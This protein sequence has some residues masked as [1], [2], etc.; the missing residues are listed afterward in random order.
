MG[1]PSSPYFNEEVIRKNSSGAY[2]NYAVQEKMTSSG[3]MT[4]TAILSA[5][6]AVSV[7][8][9]QIFELGNM[10]HGL[11]AGCG[12]LGFIMVLVM[13]FKPEV[14]K[15]IA[16]PY[17]VCEGLF[18]SSLVLIANSLYPGV[19]FEALIATVAL[20]AAVGVSYKTGLIKVNEVFMSAFKLMSIAFLCLLL[21]NVVTIFFFKDVGTQLFS[22]TQSG[23]IGIGITLFMLVYG[24]FCLVLDLATMEQGEASGANKDFEWY[25]AVSLLITIVYIYIHMLRLLIQIA[26][27]MNRD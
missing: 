16:F 17:A 22:L 19:A 4:K 23:L 10:S 1:M 14:A 20:L 6:V 13:V 7:F 11:A 2:G 26:A 5:V 12:I 21:L 18:I 9:P 3:A 15:Y 25:C 24:S 27:T 8:L